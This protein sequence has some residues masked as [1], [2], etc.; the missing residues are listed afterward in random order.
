M[1]NRRFTLSSRLPQESQLREA[2]RQ[3]SRSMYK[4]FPRTP[5]FELFPS[6]TMLV[7]PGI[8][9]CISACGLNVSAITIAPA[10]FSTVSSQYGPG[11]VVG[12]LLA[13]LSVMMSRIFEEED[14]KTCRFSADYFTTLMFPIVAIGDVTLQLYRYPGLISE[15]T[16][17]NDPMLQGKIHAFE[18]PLALIELMMMV[19]VFLGLVAMH[20]SDYG[21]EEFWAIDLAGLGIE[22]YLLTTG[23]MCKDKMP[24][25][26]FSRSFMA[27][28]IS[29]VILAWILT[30]LPMIH[31]LG[32]RSNRTSKQEAIDLNDGNE[33]QTRNIRG[34][35][36]GVLVIKNSV[37]KVLDWGMATCLSAV[38]WVVL[39]SM[40]G[41]AITFLTF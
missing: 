15:I 37:C 23:N 5:I 4:G 2:S 10:D 16:S 35:E 40:A 25:E 8:E 33:Q 19:S 1:L 14:E 6:A 30:M 39:A 11:P 12:W 38:F 26:N 13:A 22:T 20:R 28:S 34:S 41:N 36:N 3:C 27:H 24:Y 29:Q 9:K 7:F 21:G 31:S 32:R 17:T 18:A